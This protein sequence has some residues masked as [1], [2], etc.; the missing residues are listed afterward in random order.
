[1]KISLNVCG[2]ISVERQIVYILSY[3]LE[4]VCGSGVKVRLNFCGGISA[5]SHKV[6]IVSYNLGIF[7]SSE[8]NRKKKEVQTLVYEESTFRSVRE[9]SV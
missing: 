7:R 2:G 5:E 9:K 3:N 4:T 1:M 8:G 6:Y